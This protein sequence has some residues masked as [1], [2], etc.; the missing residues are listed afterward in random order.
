[1]QEDEDLAIS[2]PSNLPVVIPRKSFFEALRDRLQREG[3]VRVIVELALP[4]GSHTPEARIKSQAAVH[5]QRTQISKIQEEVLGWLSGK[6]HRVVHKF[7]TAPFLA[8]EVDQ[9]ALGVIETAA[10]NIRRVVEDRILA[11]FLAQSVPL[12]QGD[13]AWDFGYDG[14]GQV[15]A[16]LD[17]GVDKT[18]PFLA[19]KVV[20]EAC[21]ADGGDCPN[22][23][24][25]QIGEGAAVPCA[26]APDACFHGTHVAGIAAGSGSAFSGVAK[27]AQLLAIQVFHGSTTECI[28]FF[29]PIPCARAF[30]S[31]IGAAL[32]HVYEM[33]TQF[34]IAA[35]N[36]SLGGGMFASTCDDE[37]PL[38]T[39]QI[40]NLRAA[41][42][43]TT[44]ASGND[45]WTG[46]LAF[47]ACVSS[48]VSVGSTS[49]DSLVS[50]FS[51]VSPLLSLFA[52]GASINSSMPGGWF[53]V[54]DGTSMAT[55]HVA[56]AW[57]ILK[58][59]RPE[60]EAGVTQILDALKETGIPI[61]DDRG[62]P[63]VTKP[64][65]Q[66]AAA[67]GMEF[68]VPVLTGISPAAVNAIRMPPGPQGP[69]AP[70]RDA[71]RGLGSPKGPD[72]P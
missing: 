38:I 20:A 10:P 62:T 24:S 42:I 4:S 18:H 59:A 12:I 11:P 70:T 55:P 54:M 34:P 27:G 22:G 61:T 16:I 56:G 23:Q 30:S 39:S 13:L 35:A 8:L 63:S 15:I 44:V 47:P 50:S 33:R 29:E 40:D 45:G 64:L 7:R 53:E 6:G 65:I 1:M 68:P 26:F 49:K 52:P 21:F 14:S 32:E 9:E 69:N 37:D 3:S 43:A 25:S 67:L 41:G 28:P 2:P 19:G 46:N 66:I 58:Q 60:P 5:S 72:H 36:L 71:E 57:A 48:S 17:S 51:N 31:D